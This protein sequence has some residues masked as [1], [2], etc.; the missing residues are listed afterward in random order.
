M[1]AKK[2]ATRPARASESNAGCVGLLGFASFGP[3]RKSIEVRK[4]FKPECRESFDIPVV[5]RR[6]ESARLRHP[7]PQLS[8]AGFFSFAWEA[9]IERT[10]WDV[11][12][13]AGLDGCTEF[14]YGS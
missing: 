7:H 11:L 4:T 6:I 13:G 14:I 1:G 12:D 10:S 2:S 8:E 3:P 5:S 9:G